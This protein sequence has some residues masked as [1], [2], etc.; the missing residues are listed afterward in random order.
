MP[1]KLDDPGHR[2]LVAE[3]AA[4]A[5][6]LAGD[7]N[8]AYYPPNF[9]YWITHPV[10]GGTGHALYW[11]G[12]FYMEADIAGSNNGFLDGSVRW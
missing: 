9:W 8:G 10:G 3:S 4:N 2:T 1:Q 12:D 6:A 11:T 5:V 7:P